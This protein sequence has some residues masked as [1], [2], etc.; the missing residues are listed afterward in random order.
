MASKKC[1]CPKC[2][3]ENLQV[4]VK[5]DTLTT[6]KNYSATQ[7][8]CGAFM[9]GPL[10]ALCGLCGQ[11]KQTISTNTTML[12]CNDCGHEFKRREDLAKAVETVEKEKNYAIPFAGIFSFILFI[13]SA[14]VIQD[15]DALGLIFFICLIAFGIAA[16][17]I[18]FVAKKTLEIA[19]SKLQEYDKAQDEIEKK[20]AEREKTEQES[21]E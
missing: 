9:L 8:C 16:P 4:I 7:G 12:A 18:Y 3:S 15:G 17:I 13:I 1:Y 20:K 19:E 5:T 14:F 2:G 6:G 11:G 21:T 10:G